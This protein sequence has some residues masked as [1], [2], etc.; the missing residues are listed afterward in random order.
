M[1][2]VGG[3][4]EAVQTSYQAKSLSPNTTYDFIVSTTSSGGSHAEE[5]EVFR[6]TTLPSSKSQHV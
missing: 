5:S 2:M 3:G 4:D 6:T 1:V